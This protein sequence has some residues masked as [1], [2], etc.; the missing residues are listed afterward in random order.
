MSSL[1][2]CEDLSI[3]K[4]KKT[5]LAYRQFLRATKFQAETEAKLWN[6]GGMQSFK[7]RFTYVSSWKLHKL[8]KYSV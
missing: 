5:E 6:A 1:P 2:D 3:L 4:E 7:A 8:V